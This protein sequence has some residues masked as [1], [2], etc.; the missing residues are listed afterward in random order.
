MIASPI[1]I[2]IIWRF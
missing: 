1:L 2:E